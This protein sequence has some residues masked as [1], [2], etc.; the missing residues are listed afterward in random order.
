MPTILCE[1]VITKLRKDADTHIPYE[2]LSWCWGAPD[3]NSYI[4][5][6]KKGKI[7]A[8]Y[9]R[10]DLVYA[11]HALRNHQIDRYLWIDAICINQEDTKEKNHQIEMMAEI[12]GRAVQVCVWLGVATKSSQ[13]ALRF[14]KKEVLQLRHFDELCGSRQAS[15]KW[16][17]LLELMQ[18]PWFSRRWVVQE[19]SLARQAVMYCGSD[20]ISW[21]KFAVAV[22]LFVEV[23]TATHRLSEVIKKDP[24]FFHVPGWFEYVSAL[25]A[26]LLVEATGRLFRDNKTKRVQK[27]E[28]GLKPRKNSDE[29]LDDIPDIQ[30]PKGQPLLSL[31]YLVSNLSSFDTTV[32][33]DNIYA[34]LAISKDTTPKAATKSLHITDHTRAVL[35]KFTQKKD[36][37]VDYDLPYVDV[38][39]DFIQFCIEQSMRN[40][41]SRALD[42]ICRPW[43]TEQKVLVKRRKT[44]ALELEKKKAR[45]KRALRKAH[46]SIPTS[47]DDKSAGDM[48]GEEKKNFDEMPLPSW[49]PQLSSAP[50]AMDYK[51]GVEGLT[52]GRMNA[53]PLVGVPS[54]TQRN[55]N[56]AE[57]KQLNMK[58]F[59]FRKREKWNYYSMFV[60]GF[61][62]D[63][64]AEVQQ[65]SQ[66]GAIPTEWADFGDWPDAKGKP[67]DKFW[68]TL[69][70]DRG[71]D[72]KNPPV[73]YARACKESFSK[74]SI[75]SGAIS[76][77]DLINNERNSVVAQ[78]CRRVQAVIWNRALVKTENGTLGLVGKN[79]QKGDKICI[80]YGCSVPIVLRRSEEK[81]EKTMKE[82]ME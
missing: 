27:L 29:E 34:L 16:K 5:I 22:E 18:R 44:R 56:A 64:I 17:A 55:Y 73:Y 1:L 74:G 51:A 52:I 10:P 21:Q 42:V 75:K 3:A 41:P 76:T 40:D 2:A 33:H 26:S 50:Y 8:K 20:Q 7:Y 32:E 59:K 54:L 46:A 57:T 69:V 13:I 82:E 79:V 70:A 37:R 78:F 53:D 11:M 63:T 6:R 19:I 80:L 58:K 39:K 60:E 36:Y 49:I 35:E 24:K 31:E 15:E 38:C 43:A 14:I 30:R 66:T 81:S 45:E 65:S 71:R 68:R 47:I 9:V 4:N 23:E 12:Y 72:A 77:T 61:V 48:I 25:G 62:L 28:A 67:P